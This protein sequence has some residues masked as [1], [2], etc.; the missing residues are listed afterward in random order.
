LFPAIFLGDEEVF[1]LAIETCISSPH[2]SSLI[3]LLITKLIEMLSFDYT[4]QTLDRSLKF[5]AALTRNSYTRDLDFFVE[6]G[7]LCQLLVSL[8]LGP[9]TQLVHQQQAATLKSVAEIKT[10][11]RAV[12]DILDE[13]AHFMDEEAVLN[14]ENNSDHLLL[15][16]NTI[17]DILNNIEK[18]LD[19]ELT[20]MIDQSESEHDFSATQLETEYFDNYSNESSH[21]FAATT[22]EIMM[23]NETMIKSEECMAERKYQPMGEPQQ[24]VQAEFQQ[25]QNIC[26]PHISEVSSDVEADEAGGPVDGRTTI[27]YTKMCATPLLGELC[28]TLGMACKWGFVEHECLYWIL[29]R[30]ELFFKRST[31]FTFE[32]EDFMRIQKYLLVV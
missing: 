7:Y 31:I 4:V 26:S 13:S 9:Y 23:I 10:D 28:Q 25:Q 32:G 11:L 12:D 1:Q 3:K 14:E 5:L 6:L 18:E 20:K 27:M 2:I 29:K 17:N 15:N 21:Q 30:L 19:P 22:N 8:L 24:P 16:S